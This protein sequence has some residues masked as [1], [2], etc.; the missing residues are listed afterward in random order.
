MPTPLKKLKTLNLI[1]QALD[2]SAAG[3]VIADDFVSDTGPFVRG[4]Y[5]DRMENI[6]SFADDPIDQKD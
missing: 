4:D 3:I 5:L 6:Y 2:A 1:S